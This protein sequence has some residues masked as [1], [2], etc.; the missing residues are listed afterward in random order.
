MLL[1]NTCERREER[2]FQEFI[3]LQLLLHRLSDLALMQL[4]LEQ[5][6]TYVECLH[7]NDITTVV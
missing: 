7:C 1:V 3:A 4:I 6:S 5:P 2:Y